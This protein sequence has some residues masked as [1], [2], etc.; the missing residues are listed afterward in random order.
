MCD[1]KFIGE[2]F[3]VIP[4]IGWL[5]LPAGYCGGAYVFDFDSQAT[6]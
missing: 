1:L 5:G 6:F 4:I 3:C 2:I